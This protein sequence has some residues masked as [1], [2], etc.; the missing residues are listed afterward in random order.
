[1]PHTSARND[2]DDATLEA[3]KREMAK[4]RIAKSAKIAGLTAGI[5]RA[6]EQPS[7]RVAGTVEKIIPAIGHVQAEKAQ[8]AVEGA[9]P[10]YREIRIDNTLHGGAGNA[11]SL[12]VGAEVQVTI[13]AKA[14]QSLSHGEVAV[15]DPPS[16]KRSVRILIADDFPTILQMVKQ[17]LNAHPGF[18]VVGE[19]PD[20]HHAVALAAALKPDVIVINVNM[21][22][23]SGFEA[24]R[25]IRSRLPD[26]AIVILSSHKD[27]QFIA[28]A[29]KVGAKGYVGKS[30]ADRE[31]VRAIESAVKGEEFFVVE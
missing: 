21:P 31:L 6:P 7:T 5:A 4:P 3:V 13:E 20:G 29:R 19:A 8:I 25:R 12:K 2:R 24:A 15:L 30:D 23:M 18:E 27:K 22:T 10:L 1:M 16:A 11:V 14:Q 9:D 17:I 26:S 28:E